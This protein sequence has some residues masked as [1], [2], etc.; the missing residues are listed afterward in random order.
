MGQN[1]KIFFRRHVLIFCDS[2]RFDGEAHVVINDMNKEV[3]LSLFRHLRRLKK[4]RTVLITEVD[5]YERFQTYFK[6][7]VAGGGGVYN[8]KGELLLIHRL[9]NWDLPKGKL[10]KGE[11]PSVGAMREVEEECNVFDLKILMKLDTT[12]H[13]YFQKKWMI[14]RTHWYAMH[15]GR[16][17]QA[18]P[19]LEEDID[20]LKWVKIK[21]LN[22]EK[23]D[24]Y[25]SIREVLYELRQFSEDTGNN[26]LREKLN[27][28][29]L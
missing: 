27:R 29:L 17:K 12:L 23:L 3:I 22:I 13:I 10:E 16:H 2:E 1:Y 21:R 25:T 6:T 4:P 14:K 18:K 26:R 9:G 24:T 7:I 8:A 19:Q 20:D 15:S 28:E 11:S 5:A